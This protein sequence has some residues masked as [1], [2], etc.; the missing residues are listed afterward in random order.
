VS[1]AQ[2][3][4]ARIKAREQERA[5]LLAL[6]DLWAQAQAQGVEPET[7]RGF[8][9]DSRLLTPEQKRRSRG[10]ESFI[11]VL[12]NGRRRPRMFNCVWHHDGSQ[13]ALNPMLKAVYEHDD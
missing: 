11:E 7:V 12:R 10:A 9:F 1:T 13:T 6:L 5:Y 3:V 4:V 8:G 2:D